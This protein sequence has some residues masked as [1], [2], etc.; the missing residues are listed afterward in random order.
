M[1]E[2]IL[3]ILKIVG[4]LFL[5]CKLIGRCVQVSTPGEVNNIL[6][7][8]LAMRTGNFSSW[9]EGSKK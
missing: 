3:V 2:S 9:Q 1:E 6:G 5:L 4:T 8:S 7:K